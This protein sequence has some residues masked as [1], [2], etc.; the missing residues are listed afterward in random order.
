MIRLTRL[1]RVPLVLNSDL[2]EHIDVTPDTV[3]TL[4]TGQIIRVRESADQVI[5]R[6]VEFRRSIFDPAAAAKLTPVA[7]LEAEGAE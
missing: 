1:N 7:D 6:V 5:E 3:I 4:T 2:I